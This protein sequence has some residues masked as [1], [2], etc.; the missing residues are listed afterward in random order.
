M[1][2]E[3]LWVKPLSPSLF[4]ASSTRD[5]SEGGETTTLLTVQ[6]LCSPYLTRAK[7]LTTLFLE[8]TC[9]KI[10]AGLMGLLL[11]HFLFF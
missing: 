6:P 4:S 8:H 3:K 11:S 10:P 2:V 9:P 1:C 7:S 5:P